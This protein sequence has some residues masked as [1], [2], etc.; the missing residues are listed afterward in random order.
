MTKIIINYIPSET[1]LVFTN[2]GDGFIFGAV[3]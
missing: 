1:T 2:Y 3:V